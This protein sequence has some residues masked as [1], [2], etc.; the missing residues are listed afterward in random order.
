MKTPTQSV[1]SKCGSNASHWAD[2]FSMRN[3]GPSH[4]RQKELGRALRKGNFFQ[5]SVCDKEH[6]W[7]NESI[8]WKNKK[9]RITYLPTLLFPSRIYSAVSFRGTRGWAAI[10]RDKSAHVF[11][12]KPRWFHSRTISAHSGGGST[13]R[14]YRC[15]HS[16]NVRVRFGCICDHVL[17]ARLIDSILVCFPILCSSLIISCFAVFLVNSFLKV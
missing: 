12:G 14:P 10:A 13:V 15:H 16:F 8:R 5:C 17:L 11:C 3:L 1:M 2:C 9:K 6:K 7:V 4:W